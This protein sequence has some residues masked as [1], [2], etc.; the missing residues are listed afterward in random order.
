M[1]KP[2]AKNAQRGKSKTETH[3]KTSMSRKSIAEEG[4]VV[5]LHKKICMHQNPIIRGEVLQE[6][7][8]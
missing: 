3:K 2:S 1:P 8:L 6:K 5:R 4:E 7:L